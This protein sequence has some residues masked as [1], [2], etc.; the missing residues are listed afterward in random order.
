MAMV[1]GIVGGLISAVGTVAGGVAQAN[2]LRYQAQVAHN[3]A[4]IA[5]QTATRSLE[6]GR[7]ASE[8]KSL[9]EAEVGGAIKAAQAAGNVDVNTGS[10]VEVQKSHRIIGALN[11][12]Q[13]MS[14]AELQA[15]GYRVQGYNQEAQAGLDTAEAK[16]AEI[17]GIIGGVGQAFGAASKWFG[18]STFTSA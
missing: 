16:N 13:V 12:A 7:I 4:I 18:P 5:Q 14:N 9:E 8:N 17:G 15:Y 11:T 1:L 3:N 10:N 2:A 6:A